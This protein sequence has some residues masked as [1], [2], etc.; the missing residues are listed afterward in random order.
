MGSKCV[1]VIEDEADLLH[2][3]CDLLVISGYQVI[4][5]SHPDLIEVAI[6]DT[7]PDLFLMNVMLR[8]RTGIEVAQQLRREGYTHTPIIAMSASPT[9]LALARRSGMFQDEIDKPFDV[10]VVLHTIEHYLPLS[11]GPS[12]RGGC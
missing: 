11:G 7:S 1:A 9:M 6:A 10:D 12:S 8:G 3:I 4:A 5:I 2:M